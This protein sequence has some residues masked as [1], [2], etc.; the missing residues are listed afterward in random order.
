MFNYLTIVLINYYS[1]HYYD[2]SKLN[3]ITINKFETL[4]NLIN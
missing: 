4:K 2:V 1:V 3:F